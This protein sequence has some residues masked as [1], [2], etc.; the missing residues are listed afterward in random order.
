MC[1]NKVSIQIVANLIFHERTKHV[2]INCRFIREQ[3]NAGEIK[4]RF[5]RSLDQ[6][7]DMFTKT[8]GGQQHCRLMDKLG[9]KNIY[10]M[11]A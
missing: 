10:G 9:L 7:V 5:V 8:L 1:D 3:L 6:E 11:S 4:T 2:E